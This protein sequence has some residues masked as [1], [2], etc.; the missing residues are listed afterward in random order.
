MWDEPAKIVDFLNDKHSNDWKLQ[1]VKMLNDGYSGAILFLCQN[2]RNCNF[3]VIKSFGDASI[4]ERER[5]NHDNACRQFHLPGECLTGLEELPKGGAC[6]CMRLAG[7]TDSMSFSEVLKDALRTGDSSRAVQV[8]QFLSTKLHNLVP[9]SITTDAFN[10]EFDENFHD[11]LHELDPVL[12]QEFWRWWQKQESCSVRRRIHVGPAHGDLHTDNIFI[13]NEEH[14]TVNDVYLIDFGSYGEHP[15][16]KDFARLERDIRFRLFEQDQASHQDVTATY[17]NDQNQITELSQSNAVPPPKLKVVVKLV[18]SVNQHAESFIGG[19]T[20]FEY[21][22]IRLL[23]FIFFA[24]SPLRN[25]SRPQR[26]A[27][28]REAQKLTERLDRYSEEDSFA[29]ETAVL[30]RLAYVFLRLEQLPSGG[31]A[32]SLPSWYQTFCNNTEESRSRSFGLRQIGGMNLT[33]LALLNYARTLC[34]VLNTKPEELLRQWH[35]GNCQP[36]RFQDYSGYKELSKQLGQ[37]ENQ[38]KICK[39]ICRYIDYRINAEGA[40]PESQLVRKVDTEV[41]HTLLGIITLQ[42]A[43]FLSGQAFE[44]KIYDDIAK[45]CSY[46]EMHGGSVGKNQS[47]RYEIY[48]AIVFLEHLLKYQ[49]FTEND[50]RKTY[51]ALQNLPEHLNRIREKICDDGVYPPLPDVEK[52]VSTFLLNL[53]LL[54]S[55]SGHELLTDD[56]SLTTKPLQCIEFD[57]KGLVRCLMR[58]IEISDWGHTAEYWWACSHPWS[59]FS[60]DQIN[61]YQIQQTLYTQ[62]TNPK[63]L[64]LTH[65]ISFSYAAGIFKPLTTEALRQLD[66]QVNTILASGATERNILSLVTWIYHQEYEDFPLFQ[67]DLD[68]DRVLLEKFPRGHKLF[69]LASEIKNLLI[70]KLQPGNYIPKEE[71]MSKRWQQEVQL[72]IKNTKR[73]FED[74][75]GEKNAITNGERLFQKKWFHFFNYLGNEAATEHD[76]VFDVGCGSGV[77]AIEQFLPKGYKVHFFDCSQRILGR[78][79]ERLIE[80]RINPSNYEIM[81]DSIE[82]L[83]KLYT[84]NPTKFKKPYRVIFADAVLFHVNK[85]QVPDILRSFHQML[86]KDGFFFTNFKVNDHS[87]IGIDGRFF[88]YYTNHSEIQKML[89]DVGFQVEDV[90]MTYKHT[91]MYDIPYPTHWAHFIC[92][93]R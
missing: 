41:H 87:L 39:G 32:R 2:M 31:W 36:E 50:A 79:Q 72:G 82:N 45:M 74:D 20:R 37:I 67:Q 59:G 58:D 90:T 55:L 23:E 46:L 53:P 24:A 3:I 86:D 70:S 66:N 62:L 34:T 85:I 63:A 6:F 77:H 40:I 89:E 78:L 19:N 10:V 4:A 18:K 49:F 11:Q 54:T 80:R 81:K 12:Y 69:P 35:Q 28:F 42:L 14:L 57:E 75:L 73:F 84:F 44:P 7:G 60:P 8:I 30:W 47:R 13:A 92:S 1:F 22:Y 93:K 91:S 25:R 56:R 76:W 71:S 29:K 52:G 16:L 61:R 48:C 17:L 88:E 9:S 27:A 15:I 38:N 51:E 83:S 26:L 5:R 68:K 33:C 65:G 21:D 64:S 43:Y